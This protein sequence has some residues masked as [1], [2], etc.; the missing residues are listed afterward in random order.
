MKFP[1][2]DGLWNRNG[3]SLAKIYIK[4]D[5]FSYDFRHDNHWL[6]YLFCGEIWGKE[7]R[8]LIQVHRQFFHTSAACHHRE[9]LNPCL[10]YST[11]HLWRA[12]SKHSFAILD[13]IRK[14][15]VRLID[16]SYFY[17]YGDPEMMYTNFGWVWT[18][19]GYNFPIVVPPL[20]SFCFFT[21]L[22][23]HIPS[24]HSAL[25]TFSPWL[26]QGNIHFCSILYILIRPCWVCFWNPET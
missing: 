8:L 13:A 2:F 19:G 10:E 21:H 11:S 17:S 23:V 9:G 4:E 1:G 18:K 25:G 12:L 7:N 24:Y 14:R 5:Q 26:P 3:I 16:D 20:V 6:F 22:V 15:A